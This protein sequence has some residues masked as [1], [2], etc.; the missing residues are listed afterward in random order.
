MFRLGRVG[1]ER[2]WRSM[3]AAAEINFAD[4]RVIL[5]LVEF[6]FAEHRALVKHRDLSVAGDL[7]DKSH[8]VF[9]DDQAVFSRERKKQFPRAVRLVVGHTRGWFVDEE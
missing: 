5:H 4:L 7:A 3:F 1:E 9:D 2:T 6:S 8:V